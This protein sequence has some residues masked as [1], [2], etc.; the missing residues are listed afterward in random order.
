[1]TKNVHTVRKAFSTLD[2]SRAAADPS[3][4]D[5]ETRRSAAQQALDSSIPMRDQLR[6]QA[7]SQS[8]S[9]FIPKPA[10]STSPPLRAAK[11]TS[12]DAKAYCKPFCDFLTNNPTVFHAISAIAADLE[13][14]GF[15]KLSERDAWK[16]KKGGRYY[17]ERNG[18]SMIAFE[19]GG[20]YE[21]GNGAA[22]LAGP[23]RC[24]DGQAQA[25]PQAAQ[26]G[27]LPDARRR[28]VRRRAQ[29]DVVGPRPGASAEGCWSRRVRARSSRSWSSSTGRST[30]SYSGR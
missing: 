8:P 3:L 4:F 14:A 24:A 22:M 13:D 18:S 28:A 7:Q 29:L 16:L 21:A 15:S 10:R 26:Q 23:R 9:P 17:V 20:A 12:S 2:I 5:F 25:H 19:V 6:A 27:R 11:R 30:S 1:M